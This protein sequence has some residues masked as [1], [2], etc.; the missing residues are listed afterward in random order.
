M[1]ET[2]PVSDL[3]IDDVFAVRTERPR[4]AGARSPP[5]PLIDQHAIP[6]PAAPTPV[7]AAARGPNLSWA[8]K[9]EPE[10]RSLFDRAEVKLE[11]K[12]PAPD[13]VERRRGDRGKFAEIRRSPSHFFD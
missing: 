12:A 6:D 2:K 9:D 1:S 5:A 10:V 4:P 8:R 7:A 13:V 11:V 3:V